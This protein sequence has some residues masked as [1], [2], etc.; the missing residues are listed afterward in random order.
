MRDLNYPFFIGTIKNEEGVYYICNQYGMLFSKEELIEIS[1]GL[2]KF[3]KKYGEEIENINFQR[4]EESKKEYEEWKKNQKEKPKEKPRKNG[5]IYIMKCDA[6]YKIGMST[7][8]ER[9]LKQLDNRPFPCEIVFKSSDT[10]YAYEVE[11]EIHLKL[12]KRRIKGEWYEIPD[13]LI[14]SIENDIE[15]IIKNYNTGIYEPSRLSKL[16]SEYYES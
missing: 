10:K 7:L 4:R 14:E 1:N 15:D 9:R 13:N 5:K 3:V 2:K 11:Q 16:R 6:K 8:V 12:S